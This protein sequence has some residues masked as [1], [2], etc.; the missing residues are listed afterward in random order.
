MGEMPKPHTDRPGG[1]YKQGIDRIAIRRW[2]AENFPDLAPA[3]E[4]K[5]ETVGDIIAKED[6]S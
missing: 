1:I 3:V 4:P 6:E 2:V 5:I